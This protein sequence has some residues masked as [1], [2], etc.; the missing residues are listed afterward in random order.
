MGAVP[1]RVRAGGRDPAAVERLLRGLPEWF[2][3]EASVRGYVRDAAHLPGYLAVGDNG[4]VLGALL[5]K[6]H[7]P[8]AAE[9]HLLAVD[10]EVHR[11]GIGTALLCAAEADLAR[12]GVRLL[13]VKTLGPSRPDTNYEITRRF[14]AARGFSPL[15]EI[16]GLWPDNPCLILV[17]N[18]PPP[19]GSG[20]SG[21]EGLTPG[22]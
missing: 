22:C 15:E 19:T 11:C 17:K 1:V 7:F 2:G 6:V 18:L 13:Q 10:R 8:A 5:V 9:I 21:G 4:R 3:V 16:G 12:D 20:R 14:Y